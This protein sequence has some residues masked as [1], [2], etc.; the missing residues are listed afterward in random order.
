MKNRYRSLVSISL[1]LMFVLFGTF[2]CD[3]DKPTSTTPT[4]PSGYITG[5]VFG[6]GKVLISGVTVKVGSLSTIT[7]SYGMYLLSGVPLGA[8]VKV[9]FEKTGMVAV[10]KTTVVENG[11]TAT[12]DCTMFSPVTAI[13]ASN[14]ASAIYDGGAEVQ[15]PADAFVDENG[16]PFTGSVKTELKY[17]DPTNSDCLNAFPGTF[18]GLL[19]DGVTETAFESYGFLSARFFDA[20]KTDS[21]LNLASGKTA[22]LKAPIPWTLQ[23]NAPATIPMWYYDEAAG[24]WK[25]QGSAT[26]IN[27]YYEGSVSHFT[28]WNFDQP[29]TV[30]NEAIL[31]GYVKWTDADGDPVVSAQL[32]AT[33]VDYSGYTRVYTNNEGF[34]SINVKANAQVRLRAYLGQNSTSANS[35]IITTPA[36]GETLG[37]NNLFMTDDS[38][39]LNGRILNSDNTP[40]AASYGYINKSGTNENYGSFQTDSEGYFSARIYPP[41]AKAAVSVIFSHG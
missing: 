27:G 18:T 30:T 21:E 6:Q 36:G 9:D 13:I 2:A 33:G 19:A 28:Y 10:Q 39:I 31:E 25:E 8:N 11:K 12:L 32:V 14:T 41:S 26:K 1:L 7:D 24:M 23:S 15:L 35:T 4:T 22:T 37:N 16:N 34:F 5:T 29:I 40:L 20:A 17:F 3:K 38:F